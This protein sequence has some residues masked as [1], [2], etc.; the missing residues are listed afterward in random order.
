MAL[1]QLP[2]VGS[3]SAAPDRLFAYLGQVSGSAGAGGV[4]AAAPRD[5]L[6]P[7]PPGT[8][9]YASAQATIE[10]IVSALW[11]GMRRAFGEPVNPA[12][13]A[14]DRSTAV[15]SPPR[16]AAPQHSVPD[17]LP[18]TT[19]QQLMALLTDSADPERVGPGDVPDSSDANRR[20]S[21]PKAA[22]TLLRALV[23]PGTPAPLP[24]P[25]SSPGP[26]A[27]GPTAQNT[28]NITVHAQS[29]DDSDLADQ[30]AE[31]LTNQARRHGIDLS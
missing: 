15:A 30:I 11:G 19:N 9:S 4:S 24:S 29:G 17:A 5:S 10:A 31:I 7:A 22:L 2:A 13:I 21:S 8:P 12:E 26:A 28:F 1:P 25:A 6:P 18:E 20:P 27:A 23:E 16:P 3:A 14:I